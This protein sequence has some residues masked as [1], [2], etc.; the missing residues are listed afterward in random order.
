MFLA[1]GD[2]LVGSS[3]DQIFNFVS[4]TDKINLNAID[5]NSAANANQAFAFSAT[6]PAAHSV[7]VIDTGSHLIVRGDVTGDL[8]ADFEIQ[9]RDINQLQATDFLL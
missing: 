2:S 4:G 8:T 1:I 5:A 7:W 3:R 9:V 6:G